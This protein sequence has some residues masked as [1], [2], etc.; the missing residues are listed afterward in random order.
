MSMDV[1]QI[2]DRI[3]Q[4]GVIGAGGA[5]FPTHVKYQ[6]KV[7]QVIANGAEC[8]PLI[9]VDQ[10]QMANN[11]QKVLRGLLIAME[12]T[13][14]SKGVVALKA[15]YHD[16]IEALEEQIRLQRL[17]DRVS[18]FLLDNFYPAGDEFVLVREVTGAAIPEF[19][20]PLDVGVVVSNVST[21]M[22]VAQAV[23][24][25]QAVI[26]RAV[27]VTGRVARPGTFKVPVGTPFS[28]LVKAAGGALVDPAYLIS[29]GPMMGK[30][31]DD[32]DEPV[33]KTTSA[34]IVLEAE[35]PVVRRRLDSMDRQVALTRSACLKCMMCTEVCPRNQL[36]HRLVPD[37]LMR[38]LAAGVVEDTQAFVG[39]YLCSECGLCAVYGCVMNL[40]PCRVNV[41]MKAKLAQAGVPKPE[42]PV[43]AP[44]VFGDMR[45]V[46]TVR[47]MARLGLMD[48]D[49]PAP[50]TEFIQPIKTL[51]IPLNQHIGVTATATVKQGERVERGQLIGEVPE[52]KLGALVHSPSAGLVSSVTENEVSIEL[53]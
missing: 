45:R 12:C 31:V 25:R 53:E 15:K 43:S 4:A 42:A 34:L 16:A 8:E 27:T 47:L 11:P 17:K 20:L 49:V 21:L 22:D 29:G 1:Q 10:Q 5:G 35:S 39:S 33:T 48:L 51:R 3:R 9:R 44:R 2:L 30:L 37:R 46:P 32:E 28:S 6:A 24:E 40:D 18:L 41:M 14:A 36:G 13:G 19:G 52:G 38:N 7:D 26:E 23:D 50:M